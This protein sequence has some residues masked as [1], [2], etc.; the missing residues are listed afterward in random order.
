MT[1]TGLTRKTLLVD[2]NNLLIRSVFAARANRANLTS[3]DGVPTAALLIFINLLS[4]YVK[5][6]QPDYMSVCWDGGKSAHRQALYSGYKAARADAP[7]EDEADKPFAQAKEFLTLAGIHHIQQPGVEADDLIAAYWRRKESTERMFI[8]SGDKDFLQLL[9][10]WTE[11]IRPGTGVDERWTANRV[12]SEMGCRP[13]HLPLVMALTGD[14]SDNV[15]GIPGF[16]QKTAC[17]ALA[18]HDW[19]LDSL[20]GCN[21]H[22][23]LLGQEVATRRNLSLVDLR[24]ALPGVTVAPAP[25]FDPTSVISVAYHPLERFLTRYGLTTIKQRLALDSLWKD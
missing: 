3:E 14:T 12:R 8:L 23:K 4:K 22:P 18:K 11:Q 25:R 19:N 7:E 21:Q 9:D 20:L 24:T 5:Q 17:K 6:V 13:E 1:A 15:P 16:G 10:G 2:G